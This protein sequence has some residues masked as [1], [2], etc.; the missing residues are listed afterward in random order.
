[1]RNIYTSLKNNNKKIAILIDP[2][3]SQTESQKNSF[4]KNIQFLNPDFVFIGGSTVNQSDFNQCIEFY[5]SQIDCPII[6][7][8]GSQNQIHQKADAILFLSLISGRNPDFLIG[9]Q[10]DAAPVIKKLEI[11]S[12]STGYMLIDGGKN[13]SVSYVSQTSPIP[14]DQINIAVNTAIAGEMLGMKTIFM[15]AG[16][17]ALHSVPIE[18][19]K[20]V[21]NNISIPLIIGGGIKSIQQIKETFEAGAD[22]VV[23]GNKIEDDVDFLLDI[24][25]YKKTLVHEN[26]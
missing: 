25:S 9:H 1:M 16:S 15:D 13:S 26:I 14:I 20:R 7:F 23:I 18:M 8:P 24:A 4:L 3:K 10:I 17:G 2:D 22:I 12:I 5:K 11:E 21:K 6:I 19:I